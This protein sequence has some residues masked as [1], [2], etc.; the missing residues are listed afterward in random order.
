MDKLTEEHL[1]EIKELFKRVDKDKDGIVSPD[2]LQQVLESI[3]TNVPAHKIS[4]I[5][6][7][8]DSN[9]DGKICY[10]E[11][12]KILNR[13]SKKNKLLKAFKLF[14]ANGDG[15]ISHEELKE[16]LMQTGGIVS[17]IELTKM[18]S[19]VD[20]DGDGYLSY[21]EFLNIMIK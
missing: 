7:N 1:I 16:V 2:E 9:G 21:H 14:D 10:H 5:V 6:S 13:R 15:K 18:I 20:K 11:F 12:Y 8:A 19:D 4:K 3:F 17:E